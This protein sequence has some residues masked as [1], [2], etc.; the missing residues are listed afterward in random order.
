MVRMPT[1]LRS[2]VFS[3]VFTCP[4]LAQAQ[5]CP[6]LSDY[7]P[8]QQP[9][10]PEVEQRLLAILNQCL[11]STEYFSLLGAAQLNSGLIAEAAES[12]ER[13][14]L[15]DPNNG[16][17]QIDYSQ[18]LY[19]S[20]QL[21]SALDLN[22]QLLA[23]EDL[24]SNLQELLLFREENWRAQTQQLGFQLD[25]LAGYD[26]NLNGA[27]TPD[28]I[29]LTLSGESVILPLNPDF[30][31]ISGPYMS[32][33]LGGRF[34]QLAPEHQT[35]WTT[36]V[37]GRF[38]EDSD[39]DLLQIDSRYAFIKPGSQR[40]WQLDAGVSNLFFGGDALYTALEGRA[41]YQART[42]TRCQPYYGLALQQ[43]LFHDQS[44]LNALESK[45]SAGVNCPIGNSNINQSVTAE[46]SGL[47]NK[48]ANSGRPGGDRAGW[49]ARIEWQ[50]A[51]EIGLFL[52]QLNH[53]SIDDRDGYS[54]LIASGAERWLE[55][56]YILLQ[57]RKPVSV[58]GRNT[59][60]LTN[61]YHQDQRSNIELFR[62]VDT[63][64]EVGLSLSF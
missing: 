35:N 48:A 39:S 38:S 26:S 33:R 15:L 63:T 54:P 49:Q 64:F 20:G 52:A 29:T 47:L 9:N 51:T 41:R 57:Y 27:P 28:Q 62:T 50:Y 4:L 42:A 23:R 37:N 16:G 2:F 56:S 36:Q 5:S 7:Y 40:S 46:I 19:E 24:P 55:R 11:E 25:V 30:E 22:A 14:I 58:F 10:W 1:L 31:T 53:T 12:L 59:T 3:V 44:N 13:A 61:I 6:D 8:G 18:T 32:F 60:L 34:R 21:F 43:Q 45:L 17:A